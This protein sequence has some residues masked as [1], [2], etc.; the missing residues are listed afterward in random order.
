MFTL[1]RDNVKALLK[2]SGAVRLLEAIN[3]ATGDSWLMLACMDRMVEMGELREI[4]PKDKTVQQYRV[5]VTTCD[6][7]M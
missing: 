5:F 3:D 6:T 1:I 7:K 4:T 2:Q